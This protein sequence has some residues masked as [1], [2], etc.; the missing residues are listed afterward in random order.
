MRHVLPLILLVATAHAEADPAAKDVV[1][2]VQKFYDTTK[3]LHAKFDQ[4]LASAMGGNAKKASGDVWLKKPGKMRWDYAKPEKKAM[5]ADGSHLWVYE[6]EDAQ[7]FK[8]CMSS[9]TLPA[10][11]SFLVGSGKLADE[12]DATVVHPKDVGGA[13][14]VVLKM[15]PKTAS[16]SYRY[17]LFVTDG[18][19][20]AVKE[21]VIYDQQGGSNRL[22]FSAVEQNKSVADEKFHFT[23]PAGV[24]VITPPGSAQRCPPPSP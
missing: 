1:A 15:I 18:K 21:T 5:V 16:G 14:D 3:D 20:G 8:Q 6:E 17:L 13:G 22:S 4:T 19:T 24:K 23:P 10:Q 9:S 12:F 2:R 11:V 7:V